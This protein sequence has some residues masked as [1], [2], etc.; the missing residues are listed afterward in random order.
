VNRT[1]RTSR[2]L[3]AL[4][5]LAALAA[6]GVAPAQD[7]ILPYSGMQYEYNN[8]VFALPS[9][10]Q[11]QLQNGER[12]LDDSVLRGVLGVTLDYEFG[13][14]RLRAEAEGG[15]AQYLHFEPLS[16][17]EY[18]YGAEFDWRL[19]DSFDGSVAY[20]QQRSMPS[21]VEQPGR[22]GLTIDTER[23]ASASAN[24]QIVPNWRL[25]TAV[26]ARDLESPLPDAPEF[27]LREDAARAALNYLGTASLAAGVYLEYIA[28]EFL[29]IPDAR[30]FTQQTYGLHLSYGVSKLYGIGVELGYTDRQD[31]KSGLSGATGP[32][33]RIA[34]RRAISGKTVAGVGAFR[35]IH[36]DVLEG[37]FVDERGIEAA[38]AVQATGKS[39][40]AAGYQ[41]RRSSFQNVANPVFGEGR[42]DSMHTLA[43]RWTWE[44]LPSLMVRA[45]AGYQVRDSNQPVFRFHGLVFGVGFVFARRQSDDA[46][47]RLIGIRRDLI[48]GVLP[49]GSIPD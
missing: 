26:R 22:A 3:R 21:F 46:E 7:E 14:Q 13:R 24:V 48:D 17:A 29:N 6:S 28:G 35:E 20:G 4:C 31:D 36:S 34:Y 47:T 42:E 16:H 19:S 38:L 18:H 33:G 40:A 8:N 1:C 10:R 27:E 39:E 11:A 2:T 37:G 5:A 25:E 9:P 43:L 23:H 32:T 49:Q 41:W 44:A 15:Y 30:E 12:K 45:N